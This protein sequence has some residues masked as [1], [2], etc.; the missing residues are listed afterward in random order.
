MHTR[1]HAPKKRLSGRGCA[2]TCTQT[3]TETQ[4]QTCV[5]TGTVTGQ[6]KTTDQPGHVIPTLIHPPAHSKC[7]AKSQ[8]GRMRTICT[9]N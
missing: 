5:H 7:P 8:N 6:R 3:E 9:T 2:R 4:R 1:T